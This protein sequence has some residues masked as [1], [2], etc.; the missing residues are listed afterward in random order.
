[1]KIVIAAASGNI[2][3]RTAE[4]VVQAG[5]ETIL[6]TRHP[7]KLADLVAQGGTVK[8]I[9]SDDT[10]GLIEA[11]QNADALFWLTP[12]KLDVPSLRDWY[13]RNGNDWS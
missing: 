5:A 1:M 2:G 7:E 11:T 10:Q 13:I 9:S 12:P 4:K 8:P 3:R 6:L